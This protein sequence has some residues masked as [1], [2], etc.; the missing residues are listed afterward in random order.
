MTPF[1]SRHTVAVLVLA[2]AALVGALILSAPPQKAQAF[3]GEGR[4]SLV[5]GQSMGS[6]P[7]TVYLVDTDSGKVAAISFDMGSKKFETCDVRDISK[8]LN[9]LDKTRKP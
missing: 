2:N 5:V 6:V 7:E 4:V 3:G 8:D 1:D 9:A